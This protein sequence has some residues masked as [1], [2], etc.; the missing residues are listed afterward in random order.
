[1]CVGWFRT[2]DTER[3]CPVG[4]QFTGLRVPAWFGCAWLGSAD[5]T[6]STLNEQAGPGFSNFQPPDWY[7]RVDGPRSLHLI[8]EP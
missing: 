4:G 8:V 7:V 5:T 6:M 2:L 3:A 1:M